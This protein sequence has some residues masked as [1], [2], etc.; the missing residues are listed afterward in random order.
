MNYDSISKRLFDDSIANIW[1]TQSW[2]GH[3]HL[4]EGEA[5]GQEGDCGHPAQQ[6]TE[7]GGPG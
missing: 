2:W 7:G 5:E 4:Q 1:I 3:V 6:E